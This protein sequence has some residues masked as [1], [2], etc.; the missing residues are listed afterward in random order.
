VSHDHLTR[1]LQATWSGQTLLEL[2]VRTRF[3]WERG[4]LI[5]DDTVLPQPF[6]TAIAGLAWV[7]SSQE[8]KPVYG[9]SLVWL[10]WTTGTLRIPLS[11]RLWHQGGP[12]KYALAVELLGY[13]RHRLRCRPAY[14]LFDAWYP[15]RP[16]LKRIRD[17]GWYVVCRLKKNRRFNGHA[18]RQP[19][20]QPYWAEIGWLSGGLK[21]LVV[22]HGR[23]YYATKRLTLPAVEVRQLYRMRAQIEE[24]I[25][26]CKDQRR[27][28]GCQV[29][30]ERAQVHHV[31]CC[32]VAFCILERERH[33][34][35]L[36]IYK[37]KHQLSCQG[38]TVILPALERL[39][40][41]A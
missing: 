33:D 5:I 23:K 27:L 25:R 22:R 19:R 30:S 8:R 16:L 31:T 40:Q 11:M 4:D 35:G 20:R 12:S 37:L 10:V 1:L 17:D 15:S 7:F 18:V 41:A 38:R 28:S 13:A 6:A 3:V 24:V 2:A 21:V 32:L 14:G 39:K 26:V 29:R 34:R 36:T 9:V